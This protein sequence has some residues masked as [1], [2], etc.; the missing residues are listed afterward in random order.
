VTAP[1][2][3]LLLAEGVG[4]FYHLL[5]ILPEYPRCLIRFA[6]PFTTQ[7]GK[8]NSRRSAAI[9]QALSMFQAVGQGF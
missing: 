1:P 4:I 6:L 7:F 9:G 5:A 2:V 8:S 3:E